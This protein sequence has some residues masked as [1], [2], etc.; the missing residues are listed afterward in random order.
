MNPPIEREGT[1]FHEAG[2]AV[3]MVLCD[4]PVHSVSIIPTD[5]W[6][7][8]CATSPDFV[9]ELEER[10][11]SG[12]LTGD[13]I[14]REIKIFYAGVF[15]EQQFIGAGDALRVNHVWLGAGH[16][17][18][19]MDGLMGAAGV[20]EEV[21]MA[22]DLYLRLA[23]RETLR[24]PRVWSRWSASLRRFSSEARSRAGRFSRRFTGGLYQVAS[25]ARR[26]N[27]TTTSTTNLPTT[28]R[29]RSSHLRGL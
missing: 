21:Q 14:E 12:E 1:A 28:F 10:K 11:H 3:F 6:Q 16:D 4:E 26:T 15:A 29:P 25:L 17:L 20:T 27:P 19:A 9:R 13:E 18:D 2:H 7:G 24:Q 5:R 8:N 22:W 23:V